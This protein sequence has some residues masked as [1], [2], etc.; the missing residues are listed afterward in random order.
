M[1]GLEMHRAAEEEGQDADT[2]DEEDEEL[3]QDAM[4]C[5]GAWIGRWSRIFIA[6]ARAGKPLGHLDKVVWDHG[7]VWGVKVRLVPLANSI[8][9]D[10]VPLSDDDREGKL[11]L[12]S[13]QIRATI[14]EVYVTPKFFEDL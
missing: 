10:R 4:L 2:S 3:E 14:Q 5:P 1:P 11:R 8:T 13:Y 6:R 12:E 7:H 9:T